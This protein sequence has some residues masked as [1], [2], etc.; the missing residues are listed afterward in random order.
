MMK[1]KQ[2]MA[3]DRM[4]RESFGAGHIT[5][6]GGGRRQPERVQLGDPHGQGQMMPQDLAGG[7]L[8]LAIPGS[9]LGPMGLL[10]VNDLRNS[11]MTQRAIKAEN[12]V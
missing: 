1:E 8:N 5:G 11:Q 7:Y 12:R 4:A 2:R 6:A 9:P 10:A 3:G